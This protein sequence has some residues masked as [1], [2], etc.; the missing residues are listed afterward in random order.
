MPC[1]L[2]ALSGGYTSGQLHLYGTTRPTLPAVGLL[3]EVRSSTYFIML[4]NIRGIQGEICPAR[5]DLRRGSHKEA[6]ADRSYFRR[7]PLG[8]NV[9]RETANCQR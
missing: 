2:L 1:A 9:R 7:L 4:Q 5:Q 8:A 3:C 6:A